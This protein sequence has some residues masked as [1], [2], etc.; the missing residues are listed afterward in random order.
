MQST[1]T[2]ISDMEFDSTT[3]SGHIIKLD[4]AEDVGGHDKGPRPKELLLNGLGGCTGMDVI[5]ILRK[6]KS[7]PDH[8]RVEITS[9][10][11]EEHPR[12]FKTIKMKYIFSGNIDQEKIIKAVGLSQEKYCGVTAILKESA[13]LTYEIVYE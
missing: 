2:W 6:M 7:L 4:A 11:T 12:I 3:S 5:A 13:E 10:L 1:V 9:E 8:F